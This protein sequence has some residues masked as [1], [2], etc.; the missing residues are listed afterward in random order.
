MR[1]H[2]FIGFVTGLMLAIGAGS[3][4]AAENT[5]SPEP[6]TQ[7]W[8]KNIQVR[9]GIFQQAVNNYRQQAAAA[10]ARRDIWLFADEYNCVIILHTVFMQQERLELGLFSAGQETDLN[11]VSLGRDAAGNYRLKWEYQEHNNSFMTLASDYSWFQ[12][13]N[14]ARMHPATTDELDRVYAT[15]LARANYFGQKFQLFSKFFATIYKAY[16]ANIAE[17]EDVLVYSSAQGEV[18]AIAKLRDAN[19][20]CVADYSG[21]TELYGDLGLSGTSAGGGTRYT[22]VINGRQFPF[23][24]SADEQQITVNGK[25]LRRTTP[26]A[27]W[28]MID[29]QRL[30]EDKRRSYQD[31]QNMYN[32]WANAYAQ[33]LSYVNNLSVKEVYKFSA[34]A[35]MKDFQQNMREVRERA[36]R[37]GYSLQP[38]PYE[39]YDNT[40]T[41][42]ANNRLQWERD[43]VRY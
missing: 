3:V 2:R 35:E 7:D 20:L 29:Q 8:R 43:G 14:G 26:E 4:S 5:S 10:G 19:L 33:K 22:A 6:S 1:I 27:A 31:F 15:G 13:P 32:Q 18:V 40:A 23:E 17:E 24:M 36:A 39:Q 41:Q 21:W 38:G 30:A 28:K 42:N 25:T 34:R 11:L 9:H 12:L 37:V 16:S